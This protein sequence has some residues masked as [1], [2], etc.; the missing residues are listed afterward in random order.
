MNVLIACDKYKGSLDAA[1]VCESIAEGLSQRYPNAIIKQ[2][3]LADGGDGTLQVLQNQLSFHLKQFETT[4]P[5]QRPITTRYLTDQE[6]AYIEL[7]EAS[8]IQ[9]LT[10][11]ELDIFLCSTMGT[12]KLIKHCL[13][14]GHNKIVLSIGGSCTNDIGMGILA[15]LG[16]TFLNSEGMTLDP[17]AVNLDQIAH[18]QKPDIDDKFEL[19][20]L[21]DVDNP[22][23]GPRGAAAIYGPQKGASQEQ[24]KFLNDG[25][26]HFADIVLSQFGKDISILKGGGA[27]GGIA[28]GLFGLLTHVAIKNGFDFI[29][30]L[31]HLKEKIKN[32]DIVITGEGKLDAQSLQGKVVGRIIDYCQT[33]K[34]PVIIIAGMSDFSKNELDQL[35]IS[36]Y[37]F[38]LNLADSK[39]D[40][41]S[42]S[43]TY[44]RIIASKLTLSM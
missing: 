43:S 12:G 30:D 25:A 3:P 16:F 5:L 29:A 8:G 23:I 4:D 33:A 37:H 9:H 18:I 10:D 28:A 38:L 19:T 42:N 36:Q 32:T 21:C 1:T 26:K 14:L 2:L 31:L 6:T 22:L 13:D 7:A 27:A 44:L 17:L 41:L 15:E 20:I 34:T 40:S 24:V 35:Y 11:S 39:E